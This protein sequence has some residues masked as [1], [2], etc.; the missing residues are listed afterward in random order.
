ML[1]GNFRGVVPA[2]TV[3]YPLGV[4]D[5]ARVAAEEPADGRR[6]S[7]RASATCPTSR[8]TVVVTDS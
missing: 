4:E 3:Y 5:A 7:C 1:V 8:L 6:A 2:T